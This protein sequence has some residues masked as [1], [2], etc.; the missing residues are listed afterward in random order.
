MDCR[1]G[2]NGFRYQ[3]SDLA[4]GRGMTGTARLPALLKVVKADP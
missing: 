4:S 3:L 2:A 1:P